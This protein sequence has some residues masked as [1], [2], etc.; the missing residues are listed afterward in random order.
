M[1]Q[2]PRSRLSDPYLVVTLFALTILTLHL[3]SDWQHEEVIN[4]SINQLESHTAQVRE[5]TEEQEALIER[6]S[7]HVGRFSDGVSDWQ[8][9]VREVEQATSE[10]Q[11]SRS[12]RPLVN[13][14]EGVL[15]QMRRLSGEDEAEAERHEDIRLEM[16]RSPLAR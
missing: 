16:Q 2:Q 14:L 6:L 10:L 3:W 13:Q 15:A 9:V 5:L 7:E 8:E 11:T 12:Y 1:S 4:R